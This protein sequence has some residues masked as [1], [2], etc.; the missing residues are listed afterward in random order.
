MS[1]ALPR[2]VK[3]F[4]PDM[5]G[6][7]NRL[8]ER[9]SDCFE[10]WGYRG[11]ITPSIENLDVIALAEPELLERMF[12]F[13]DRDSGKLLALRPDMT[14]QIARL[15]SSHLKDRPLPL[16]LHYGG[17]VLHYG[18]GEKGERRE[19]YQNGLELIGLRQPEAD[20]EVIAV[21]IEALKSTGLTG[22]KI[23]VGQV[24][25]FRS[26][27]EGLSLP[28][29]L[30]GEV[31][32]AVA[33]KD[34]SGLED[35]LPRLKLKAD[36]VEVLLALPTLFGDRTV[37]DRAAGMKLNARAKKALENLSGVLDTIDSYGLMEYITV[38]LGE[39]R[40]L[41][42]Y[43]GVIFEGFVAGVGEELCGGGRYDTLL[44]RYG[45][46]AP[47][48]G[49]AISIETLMKA[50]SMQSALPDAG[51][52]DFLVVSGGEKIH[53]AMQLARALR[54]KGFKVARDIEE[55][56][57]EKSLAYAKRECMGKLIVVGDKDSAP[58]EL[59]LVDIE[60]D[61]SIRCSLADLTGGQLKFA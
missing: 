30:R 43:T 7:M 2:G 55:R 39:I 56:K 34:R 57:L 40:G 59:L 28:Y 3:D 8:E 13:E 58:D 4:L 14:A 49:F 61:K 6:K 1:I 25:F 44:G 29:D 42:Y 26:V 53:D 17:P 16:R 60:S 50:L 24:E 21:A 19:I 20:G 11:V 45:Y 23:D 31:E 37:L 27:I 46:D 35:I 41:N 47:A 36:D 32:A 51:C 15:A 9:L 33:R 22:F 5:A 52:V 48:T 38:D 18:T 54:E 10:L 12:K